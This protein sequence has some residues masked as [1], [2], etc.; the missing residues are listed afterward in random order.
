M[1]L[2]IVFALSRLVFWNLAAALLLVAF[3][4]CIGYMQPSFPPDSAYMPTAVV[5]NPTL[6]PMMDRDLLWDRLVDVID[7]Y[8][9]IQH[10]QRVRLVGDIVTEGRLDTYPRTGSTIFEPW[11]RDT[12]NRYERIESTLQSI[13]RYAAVRVIPAEAGYL[14]EVNV[15]KELEDLPRPENG[16]ASYAN[17]RNDS[18]LR[19]YSN[20]VG[21]HQPTLGWIGLGRDI[22]LEQEILTQLQGRLAGVVAPDPNY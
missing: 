7:D 4:G 16:L 15:M 21:G 2:A 9:K 8:F 14:V 6:I 5:P 20:P 22:A 1:R 11:N 19:R 18:S 3:G 17:L 13:R 12:A 10:E